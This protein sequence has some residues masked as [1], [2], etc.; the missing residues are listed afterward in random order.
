MEADVDQGAEGGLVLAL[1]CFIAFV[2][3]LYVL[4]FDEAN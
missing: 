4:R 2:N 1:T 3:I